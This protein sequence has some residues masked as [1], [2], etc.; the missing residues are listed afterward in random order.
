MATKNSIAEI[1]ASLNKEIK[2]R[3]LDQWIQRLHV[4][5]SRSQMLITWIEFTKNIDITFDIRDMLVNSPEQQKRL[6][7]T[8]IKAKVEELLDE[9]AEI[10]GRL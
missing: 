9:L 8:L 6:Y 4:R 2:D 7:R 10:E 1:A 5:E 3:G